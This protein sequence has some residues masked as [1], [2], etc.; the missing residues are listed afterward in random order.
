[1]SSFWL[2]VYKELCTKS[3]WKNKHL[4]LWLADIDDDIDVVGGIQV[5]SHTCANG[6]TVRKGLH[7]L[8]NFSDIG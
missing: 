4:Q 8:T 1:V 5:I 3:A 6:R 7:G 2:T